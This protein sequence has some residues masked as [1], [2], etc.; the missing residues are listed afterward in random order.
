MAEQKRDYYEV[1]GVQKNATDE[2]IKKAY[3]KL[4]KQY[5]PDLNP[6]DKNAEAKFKEANEA[7]AVL[8]DA[9]KKAKY[10]RF[11]HAGVDGFGGAGGG[12][13]YSDFDV[14]DIFS[15]FFGGG[16]SGNSRRR[17]GPQRGANLKYGMTLEFMEAAFGVDKDITISKEDTCSECRGSGAKAGSAPETCPTC[18]GTGRFRQQA[19]SIFGMT[20]V[21]KECPTCSGRGTVIKNPCPS[22]QGLGRRRIKKQLH[23]HVPA[24][25]D[26]GDLLPISGEGEPGTRGG[27]YG[28]LYIEFRVKPHEIFTRNG[29]NVSCNVPIS[30]TTA[31]LGGEIEVPTIDGP[32]KFNVKEG[33]Q[34]GDKQVIR[35]KGI[36]SK[37]AQNLRGDETITFTI[38]I[39]TYLSE[40][41]KTK[42]RE[43]GATL[44][45]KNYSKSAKF[46]KK[47]K[48][49]FSR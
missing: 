31:A 21:E 35:G 49:I 46:F 28:D 44:T 18:K 6:G 34:P 38:E 13:Q 27:S 20:M 12:A 45:E 1:L 7:Y 40:A 47:M 4:A 37:N 17:T 15:Q 48:D 9:D 33:T 29:I 2:E 3:R 36:P 10:D 8:S 14:S 24:G 42:L 32:V 25:V 16:F 19:Q 22:C 5:H 11:G 23:V 41:Q 43:F 26:T 30:L 39:P